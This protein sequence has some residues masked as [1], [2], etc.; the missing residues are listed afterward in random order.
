MKYLFTLIITLSVG[1]MHAQNNSITNNAGENLMRASNATLSSYGSS[2]YFYNPKRLVDGSVHLFK[3]WENIAVIFTIDNQKF[4]IRNINLN[5]ERN[6]FESKISEDS[7]FSFS[8]NNIDKF[9]VNNKI[10]KNYY[11]NHDNRIF[12]I[13]FESEE[14]TIMKGHRIHLVEGST[15]PM[16]NRNNDKYVQKSSYYLKIGDKIKSFKLTKKGILKLVSSD[17]ARA[18]KM[19]QYINDNKLSYKNEYDVKRMLAFVAIN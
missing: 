8:F 16:V 11:Y 13:I 10:F 9:V 7:I 3:R 15:N 17:K 1:V 6:T 19:E 14:F 5:I 18:T 4:R 2:T 12:E